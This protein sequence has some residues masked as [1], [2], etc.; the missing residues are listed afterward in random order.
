M[1]LAIVDMVSSEVQQIEKSLQFYA[2]H[3]RSPPLQLSGPGSSGMTWTEAFVGG[4][5]WDEGSGGRSV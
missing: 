5:A 4:G 3:G 1:I 2:V